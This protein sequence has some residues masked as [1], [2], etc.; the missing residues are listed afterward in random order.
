MPSLAPEIVRQATSSPLIMWVLAA[1]VLVTAATVFL[2]EQGVDTVVVAV[3]VS[4]PTVAGVCVYVP[5]AARQARRRME[6]RRAQFFRRFQDAD[7]H[8]P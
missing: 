3:A 8:D 6:E 7:E 5:Y 2:V 1:A 4:V